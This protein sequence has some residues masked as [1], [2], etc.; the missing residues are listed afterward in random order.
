MPQQPLLILNAVD[1]RRATQTGT[2]RAN[3]I[4]T[5]TIPPLRWASAGH[6][7]GGG[8]MGV[9]YLQK[10]IEA[11]EPAFAVMGL[12]RDIFRSMGVKD[13]WTFAASYRDTKTGR[14]ISAR[15]IFEGAIQA[16]EPDESDP[17]EFK[18]CNHIFAE[19]THFEFTLGGEEWVYFDFDERVARLM[20]ND[21]FAETR[22]ALGA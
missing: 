14:S 13:G 3:T 10:R 16:W 11:L 20:G 6:N 5:M 1:V 2:S 9:N 7:P 22:Q 19:V 12:D 15:G 17:V 4:N 21:L 18:G 8:V